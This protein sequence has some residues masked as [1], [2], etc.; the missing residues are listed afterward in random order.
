MPTTTRTFGG[1][2]HH[3]GNKVHGYA[4]GSLATG[5]LACG[6]IDGTTAAMQPVDTMRWLIFPRKKAV[7][8]EMKK[9][10]YLILSCYATKLE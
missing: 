7:V 5:M 8:T 9:T 3:S 2:T 6:S 10:E 4:R 1:E